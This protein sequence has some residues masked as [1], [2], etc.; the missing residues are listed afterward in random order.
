MWS[1]AS[2][3]K[4]VCSTSGQH[5]TRVTRNAK[6]HCR[7]HKIRQRNMSQPNSIHFPPLRALKIQF[8]IFPHHSGTSS[9]QPHTFRTKFCTRIVLPSCALRVPPLSSSFQ[10]QGLLYWQVEHGSC[11]SKHRPRVTGG[12]SFVQVI[13]GDELLGSPFHKSDRQV[14]FGFSKEGP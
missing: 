8:N 14:Y 2:H 13:L 3:L 10:E 4:A 9:T 6:V 12:T 1:A 7:V 11:F 5:T